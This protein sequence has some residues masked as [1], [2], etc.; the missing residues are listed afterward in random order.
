LQRFIF[1]AV[2]IVRGVTGALGGDSSDKVTEHV[3]L[4]QGESMTASNNS[5]QQTATHES[6]VRYP[7][8]G[9][10][11]T[12]Q[13]MYSGKRPIAREDIKCLIAHLQLTMDRYPSKKDLGTPLLL[14][15]EWS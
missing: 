4:F 8:G 2:Y 15:D 9:A 10:E 13:I 11:M 5:D 12:A 6:T 3:K 7:I 14:L 1:T